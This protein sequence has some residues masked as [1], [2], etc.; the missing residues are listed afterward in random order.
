VLEEVGGLVIDLE[1]CLVI[2]GIENEQRIHD[3]RLYYK[4]VR[5]G[6]LAPTA[7]A[8]PYPEGGAGP[9]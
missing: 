8:G 3:P 7:C 1:G 4:R 9:V 5:L 2:E 6:Y